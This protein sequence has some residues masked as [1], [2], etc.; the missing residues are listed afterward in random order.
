MATRRYVQNI[1]G[2]RT[3]RAKNWN[4]PKCASIHDYW[5]D[6]SL[7]YTDLCWQSDV[8]AFFNTLCRFVIAFLIGKNPD[9]GKDWRQKEKKASEDEMAGW[10]HWCNRHELEQTGD[11]DHQGVQKYQAVFVTFKTPPEHQSRWGLVEGG[12]PSRRE[13]LPS[14]HGITHNYIPPICRRVPPTGSQSTCW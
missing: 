14:S 7:D 1:N 12:K 9:A 10:H 3:A 13:G 5:K 6:H 8:F 11:S 2:N 4:N